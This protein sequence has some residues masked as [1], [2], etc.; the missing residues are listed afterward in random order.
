MKI[1]SCSIKVVDSVFDVGDVVETEIVSY[2]LF[3]QL[4]I[5][6]IN[7]FH[8]TTNKAK[9][10]RRNVLMKLDSIVK[11]WWFIKEER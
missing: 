6:R 3:A 2:S 9:D 10:Q 8:F 11:G 1:I 5:G 4:N 7:H